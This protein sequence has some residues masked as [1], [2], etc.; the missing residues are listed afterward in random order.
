LTFVRRVSASISTSLL[1]AYTDE[2]F[3]DSD[4]TSREFRLGATIDWQFGRH[5]GLSLTAERYDRDTTNDQGEYVENRGIV[6]LFY[7][8]QG[9]P[10]R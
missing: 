2:E 5:L 1:G 9:T 10:A 4:L 3:E 7:R 8:F 6:T